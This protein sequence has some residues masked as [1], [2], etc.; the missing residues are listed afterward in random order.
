MALIDA[1][2]LEEARTQLETLVTLKPDYA[3]GHYNLGYVLGRL[4]RRREA[5]AEY[6]L[7]L[8]FKPGYTPAQVNLALLLRR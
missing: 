5:E 1:D 8:H 3:E 7:A 6:R 2:R 4:G